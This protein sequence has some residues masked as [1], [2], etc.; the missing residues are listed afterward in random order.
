VRAHWAAAG[1]ALL[2]GCGGSQS[3]TSTGDPDAELA[4]AIEKTETLSSGELSYEV[5]G[6][7][8]SGTY[9]LAGSAI[10]DT[11]GREAK[12]DYTLRQLGSAKRPLRFQVRYKSGFLYQRFPASMAS[13]LPQGK[14]WLRFRLGKESGIGKLMKSVFNAATG[15]DPL[16]VTTAAIDGTRVAGTETLRG[17]RVTHFRLSL[18]LETAAK[19]PRDAYSAQL[20]TVLA[21]VGDTL[22]VDA[23]VGRDGYLRRIA[24]DLKAESGGEKIDID[25]RIDYSGFGR[26]VAV[27]LPPAK[28]TVNAP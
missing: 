12:F 1:I 19:H 8:S 6:G 28:E 16:P 21:A 18:P 4:R 3:T 7:D 5:K 9:A 26:A 17:E 13:Q 24:Y 23:W 25:T 20:L 27:S 10:F 2:A 15:R 11:R 22:P 14:R